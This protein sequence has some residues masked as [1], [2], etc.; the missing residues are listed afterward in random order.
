MYCEYRK[1]NVEPRHFPHF[2]L[3]GAAKSAST[4][5]ISY[6]RQ[7]PEVFVPKVRTGFFAVESE[8]STYP[9][10]DGQL[11]FNFIPDLDRYLEV[12]VDAGPGMIIGE[13]SSLYLYYHNKAAPRIKRFIP[14]VRILV[15]LRQPA[16]RAYSAYRNMVRK[17]YERSRNFAEALA[18]EESRTENNWLGPMWLYRRAGLYHQQLRTYYGAFRQEQIKVLLLEDLAQAPRNTTQCV[19]EF[20]D[21]DDS[22]SGDFSKKYKVAN[23]AGTCSGDAITLAELTE[24]YRD[25]VLRLQDLIGRDLSHWLEPTYIQPG[26]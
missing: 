13:A 22:Y 14:D 4:S 3:I 6:L 11:G 18:Q 16:A 10:G 12:F 25:D 8:T 26:I 23:A 9:F 20:L 24:S 21:V 17:G 2:L 7:H 1:S 19:F 5:L 15:I